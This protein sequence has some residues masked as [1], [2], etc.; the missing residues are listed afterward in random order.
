MNRWQV[1]GS[2]RFQIECKRVGAVSLDVN[3]QL[4]LHVVTLGKVL[5]KVLGAAGRRT[6]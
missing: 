2:H 3:G 4:G 1:R 6:A 5:V